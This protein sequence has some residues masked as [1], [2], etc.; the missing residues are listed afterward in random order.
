MRFASL[1]SGSRGNATLVQQNGTCLLVDCGFSAKEAEAR[2]ARL[3]ISA[4][5]IDAILV[6]HEHGDHISGVGALARKYDLP[7]WATNGTLSA[8]R[9]GERI[10]MNR[11]CSHTAF[12]IGDIEV[13]PFPVPHDAREPSQ[14]VFANGDKRLGLLTDVGSYTPHLQ[15]QLSG[16]DALILECNHDTEMLANGEYPLSLKHRVGGDHGHLNNVQAA[17][18]LQRIDRSKLTQLVAAHLSEKHNTPALARAALSEV[19]GC[20]PD[21]V[22]V[23][24]Q[25]MGLAWRDV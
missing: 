11:I 7:V 25:Q 24:D 2:M 16:C 13:Q 21:W 23:A 12:A 22:A 5:E 10:E 15:E 19:L 3:K 14:F 9:L 8:D 17:D 20:A 1:G 6:T 4:E 18:I